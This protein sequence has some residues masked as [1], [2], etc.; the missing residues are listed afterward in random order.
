MPA[1][2]FNAIVLNKEDGKI[3]A[4]VQQMQ[5]SQL[6]EGDV[7]VRVSYSTVNYKDGLAL[8]GSPGV[9]R[10]F[11]MIPGIDFSGV[12][13]EST[14]DEFQPGDEVLL[15]GWGV[16]ERHFG[17]LSQY[18]RVKA[19]WLMPVPQ[20]LDQKRAMAIGT[21]G[22]TAMECV[23][24]LEAH[25]LR[26]G[27]REVVVTGAAGGVGSVAVAILSTLGYKVVAST[28]RES[29]HDYLRS[30]GAADIIGRGVL[31]AA[32]PKPMEA[33][34]WGGAVD[35]VGGDTL[36]GL[37]R[38]MAYGAGIAACGL[39][40]GTALN[41][42]VFPFILRGV[43]LLGV[44]SVMVPKEIRTNIW[45]RLASD[46]PLD[47]LDSMIDVVSLEG[48]ISVA[49]EILKGNVKGRTVVDVTA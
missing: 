44:E 39:A 9:I 2:S 37:I 12:V 20:G 19:G 16:G 5:P 25:G 33:E 36:A 28:G 38:T 11:P 18:A 13:E 14:S 21:A 35:T 26:P 40:G 6:P 7:L 24:A 49:P 4:A 15:T 29:M 31:S 1:E 43:A 41:S 22:F 30:L 45:A 8:T 3:R 32:S 46:L 17:G 47:K 23:M 42:T 48:A 27:G 34:R 10:N